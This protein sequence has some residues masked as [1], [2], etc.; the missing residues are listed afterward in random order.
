MTLTATTAAIGVLLGIAAVAFFFWGRYLGRAGELRRQRSA[1]ATA[2]DTAK[3]IVGDAERDAENVRK[4]AVVAGKEELIR[5]REEWEAEARRRRDEVER[6]ERRV[7][8]RDSTLDRKLELLE[9]REKELGRR[10][11]ELG[12]REKAVSDH[13][14]ELDKLV[15]EERRRLE[16]L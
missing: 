10:A 14:A 6:E 1:Q 11:T 9:Q 16:Q 5:V 15:G 12:R 4:S 3:R 2:E 7:Q 8:D 13:Q